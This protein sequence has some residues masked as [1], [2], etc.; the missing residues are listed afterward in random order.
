MES[1]PRGGA[2]ARNP[3]QAV[4]YKVQGRGHVG[5]NGVEDRTA[6]RTTIMCKCSGCVRSGPILVVWFLVELVRHGF[7]KPEEDSA[8]SFPCSYVRGSTKRERSG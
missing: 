5:R 6:C 7:P 2:V 1:H 8:I 3:K 4:A